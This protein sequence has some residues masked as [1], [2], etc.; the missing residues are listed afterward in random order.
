VDL[1]PISLPWQ[2]DPFP[3]YAELREH[4]PLHHDPE[5]DLWFVSRHEDV[6]ALIRTPERFSSAQ[7]VVPNGFAPEVP[8]LITL[9]P[10][11]HTAMRKTVSR[12]FT[13]RRM[14]E[15]EPR[16]RELARGLVAALPDDAEFEAFEG[17]CAPL[18]FLVMAELLGLEPEDREWLERCGSL[19]VYS[20]DVTP[21][22]QH[23]AAAELTE[24]LAR[25]VERRRQAPRDDLISL[26]LTTT[27]DGEAL[28]I[29]DLL[30]LCFLLTLAGTETT[31]SGMG[32]AL[33]LLDRFPDARQRILDDPAVLPTAVDEILRYDAPVQGLSRVATEDHERHGRR[34]PAGA[35]VHLLFAAANR[36][37][38]VF[39][40]PDEFDITRS[41]NPH[42]GF[43]FGIHHCLGASLAR[44]EIRVGLPELLARFPGYRVATDRVVRAR[45]DTNRAFVRIPVAP[46]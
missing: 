2:D 45:S 28:S 31:T 13:P 16:I 42:L 39:E 26:L 29:E 32:N 40:R 23:A 21:E 10:P 44:T 5:R 6:L 7:G 46:G 1:D 37:P 33:L 12:A 14:A 9:D 20:T 35:R 22:Q 25:T 4:H 24:H 18:P 15:L 19:I 30:A 34:I 41:P 17:F 27:A 3:A 8:T 38:R 36:D 43:G 11:V